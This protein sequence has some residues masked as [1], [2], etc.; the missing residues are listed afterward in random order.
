MS[1]RITVYGLISGQHVECKDMN[2]LLGAEQAIVEAA[3]NLRTYL[4]AAATFDGR[5]QVLEF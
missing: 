5:E 1:L 4:N 3:Q 2:E